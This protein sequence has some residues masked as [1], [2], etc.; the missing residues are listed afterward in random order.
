MIDRMPWISQELPKLY[1]KIAKKIEKNDPFNRKKGI[2]KK[3]QK[4]SIS[5]VQGSLN[6]NITFLGEKLWPV[7]WNQTF[8][9]CIQSVFHTPF[10]TASCGRDFKDIDLRFFANCRRRMVFFYKQHVVIC[11]LFFSCR[12]KFEKGPI[13][14]KT[15][16]SVNMDHVF[17][18][19]PVFNVFPFLY[20]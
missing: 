15:H 9:S 4:S 11:S 7:A 5:M 16:S 6:P 17:F 18:S 12:W 2:L 3:C 10:L 20:K 14:R 19:Q 8:T 1:W 13:S